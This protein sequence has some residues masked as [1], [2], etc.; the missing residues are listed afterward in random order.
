MHKRTTDI[1]LILH[2][3]YLNP[4][5][6]GGHDPRLIYHPPDPMGECQSTPYL[7]RGFKSNVGLACDNMRLYDPV[8][9]AATTR[10]QK[11]LPWKVNFP[12]VV[13]ISWDSE[14]DMIVITF[15]GVGA[16]KR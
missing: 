7:R 1:F 10:A 11:R 5:M 15:E 12:D 16:S 4:Q 14:E 13:Q 8:A 6:G 9:L 2:N 3:L